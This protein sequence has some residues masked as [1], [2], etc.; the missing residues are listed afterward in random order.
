M[1]AQVCICCAPVEV[2][3]YAD[4]MKQDDR[5]IGV[6]QGAVAVYQRHPPWQRERDARSHTA[7]RDAMCHCRSSSSQPNSSQACSGIATDCERPVGVNSVLELRDAGQFAGLAMP[8]S[9]SPDERRSVR[10]ARWSR[11][12]SATPFFAPPAGRG[13]VQVTGRAPSSSISA[14]LPVRCFRF[15]VVL[16]GHS[17]TSPGSRVRRRCRSRWTN[18]STR[19]NETAHF[20][21]VGVRG[22]AKLDPARTGF[23]RPRGVVRARSRPAVHPRTARKQQI[24]AAQR[25]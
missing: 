4:A 10:T 12:G 6:R 19:R 23:R 18:L 3:R 11:R 22:S 20:R 1:L 16:R 17:P 15:F 14:S 24:G 2:G 13:S 5:R 21:S 8:D 25:K 7:R 9:G